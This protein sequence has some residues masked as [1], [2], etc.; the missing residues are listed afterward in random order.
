MR[1]RPLETIAGL[2]RAHKSA[3]DFQ[4]GS[5]GKLCRNHYFYS[6]YFPAKRLICSISKCRILPFCCWGLAFSSCTLRPVPPS[7]VALVRGSV[8]IAATASTAKPA[9]VGQSAHQARKYAVA[10]ATAPI[11][12][13]AITEFSANPARSFAAA[14]ATA[15]TAK[16]AMV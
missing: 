16:P 10:A 8:E 1:M 11:P 13:P 12:A 14:A 5:G 2:E 3:R 6:S 7:S 15:L 9:S 4:F